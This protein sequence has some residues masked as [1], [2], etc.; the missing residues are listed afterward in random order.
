MHNK[1]ARKNAMDDR[2]SSLPDDLIHKIFSFISMKDAI[3]SS[4]LSSRWKIM[5]TLMPYLNFEN[6]SH[7]SEFISNVFSHRNNQIQVSSLNLLLGRTVMDDESVTTILNYTFS[8]NVE[9]LTV[10]R[11][12][13]DVKRALG[14]SIKFS[15]S[16]IK[17]PRCDQPCLTTLHLHHVKL[18]DD[19]GSLFSKCTNLK[20]LFLKRCGMKETKVLNICHSRLSN[21]TLE[22]TPPDLGLKEA[23][24]VVA[25]QLKNLTTKMCE[26]KHMVNAPG[27]T[28]LVI[29][30]FHPWQLSTPAGFHSLEKVRL[31]M[32]DAQNADA[33]EIACLL[34]QLHSVKLLTL[35]LGILQ[36]LFSI[37]VPPR[38]IKIRQGRSEAAVSDEHFQ[39]FHMRTIIGFENCLSSTMKLSP[40]KVGAF[41]NTKILKFIPNV[42]VSVHLEVR[43]QEKVTIS[44]EIKNNDTCPSAIFSLVSREE[45]TA[46]GDI[47]LAERFVDHLRRMLEQLKVNTN[48]E[49]DKAQMD[50]HGK[51][52]VETHWA[53]ELQCN[54]G[55][56][57]AVLEHRKIV[58]IENSR[59]M[60]ALKVKYFQRLQTHPNPMIAWLQEVRE[61]F[62]RIERL[63][64][65]LSAS[66]RVMLQ[67]IFLSYCEDAAILTNNM[68]GWMKNLDYYLVNT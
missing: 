60:A 25:P 61:L 17:T 39:I 26:G 64:T 4:V 48:S 42:A 34:Q 12:Q 33:H 8:H 52:Q 5:W 57:L 13:L 11:A 59:M 62:E 36:R 49:I 16:F 19:N 40:H 9:Q 38:I 66:K 18:S 44:S 27:L 47:I 29:Q 14:D 31:Y 24:N 37:K 56:I 10:K 65:Q 32:Y 67:P 35:N 3:K 20:N 28:S 15:Y 55:K 54:L 6:Q 45:I 21:L 1:F 43:A 50:E 7:L 22:Y 30:G 63:I 68:L 51:P 23:V 58:E 46:M 41:A 2:L 53:W